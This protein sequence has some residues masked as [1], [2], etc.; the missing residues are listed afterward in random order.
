[1]E[2]ICPSC[3]KKYSSRSAVS[4]I[5]NRTSICPSC[6]VR[7]ALEGFAKSKNPVN[8]T[9]DIQ[10][11]VDEIDAVKRDLQKVNAILKEVKD[12]LEGL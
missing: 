2:K 10:Q 4:R 8:R 3:E 7:E 9:V 6:G 1:M 11:L 12:A 5:D